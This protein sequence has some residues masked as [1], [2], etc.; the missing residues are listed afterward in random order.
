MS[1]LLSQIGDLRS[2]NPRLDEKAAGQALNIL[3]DGRSQAELMKQIRSAYAKLG[4]RL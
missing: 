3:L 1:R 4:I 2:A